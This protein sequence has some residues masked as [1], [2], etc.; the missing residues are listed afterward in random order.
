MQINEWNSADTALYDFFNKTFWDKISKQDHTFY[1]EVTELRKKVRSL[2]E[3]C[4]HSLATNH[5]TGE[6]EIKLY[7]RTT[8]NM[9]KYLCE[10]MT[11]KEKSYILYLKK[12]FKLKL[13]DHN[14]R[15]RNWFYEQ[16]NKTRL[17]ESQVLGL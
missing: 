1:Q 17:E 11:T 13:K 12:K 4:I 14:K 6:L 10:K 2:E 16:L 7:E 8:S 5:E 15:L 3:E 9:N